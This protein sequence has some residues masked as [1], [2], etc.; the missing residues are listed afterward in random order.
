MGSPWSNMKHRT[1]RAIGRLLPH[2]VKAGLQ[3]LYM[4]GHDK[5]VD[6]CAAQV[7]HALHQSGL[8]G[9]EGLRC[10]EIGAGWVLSHALVLHLLGAERVI[11]CDVVAQA[12]PWALRRALRRSVPSLIRD[13]LSP[14]ADHGAIRE[15][16][17]RVLRLRDWSWRSLAEL[18][19][20]YRAPHDLALAPLGEP[21][22]FV[23]SNS[24]LEHVASRDVPRLLR[25]L[26]AD[27]QPGGSMLHCIHL[28]D[29]QDSRG[30]PFAFLAPQS[31]FDASEE[32]RR[33]KRLRRSGWAAAFDALSGLEWRM[34][35]EW[36]RSS[37]LLPDRIDPTVAHEGTEDLR[38][39]HLGVIATRVD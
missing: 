30:A 31:A 8:G 26:V 33:G 38:V 28:E 3:A 19:I 4:S 35:Y 17:D 15:R 11:A 27:L 12:K 21:V 36:K 7:A 34:A 18:G 2:S 23:Y 29:H 10:L 32:G 6:L 16:L 1:T 13:P 25:N 39:S 20:H 9:V 14:F 22:D 24:V 5:R 37:S